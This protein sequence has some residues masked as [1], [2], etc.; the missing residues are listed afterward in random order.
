MQANKIIH[1]ELKLEN[2]LIKY[3]NKEET[4]YII[5]LG[6][7]GIGKFERRLFSNS[8][9]SGLKGSIETVAPEII[10]EKKLFMKIMLIYIV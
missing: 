5:K 9:F 3:K 1:R 6:D 2:F 10:L 8:S 4:D 7:Y